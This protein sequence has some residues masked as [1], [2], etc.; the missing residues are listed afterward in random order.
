M[1]TRKTIMTDE[2]KNQF[3]NQFTGGLCS[4]QIVLKAEMESERLAVPEYVA[5]QNAIEKLEDTLH[6]I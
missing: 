3:L 2:V 1:T 4:L 6:A 5:I